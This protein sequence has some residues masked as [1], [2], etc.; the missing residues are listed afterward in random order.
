MYQDGQEGVGPHAGQASCLQL[1]LLVPNVQCSN[2]SAVVQLASGHGAAQNI[3]DQSA[4]V[5][6]ESCRCL[7]SIIMNYPALFTN[8][9][10]VADARLQMR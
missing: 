2:E 5:H 4:A 6:M 8:S 7:G 10:L 3:T 9:S 1:V